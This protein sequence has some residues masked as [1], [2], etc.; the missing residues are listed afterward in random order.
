M[1][2]SGRKGN[3]GK[4]KLHS[5]NTHHRRKVGGRALPARTGFTLVELLVVIAIVAILASILMPVFGQAR[6]TAMRTR[7]ASNLRNIHNAVLMYAQDW[8]ECMPPEIKLEVATPSYGTH[9]ILMPYA[10]APDI[11]HCPA[12]TGDGRSGVP[13][14]QRFGMSYKA[15]G[16]CFSNPWDEKLQM[17]IIRRLSHLDMGIDTKKV[18]KG[19][20]DKEPQFL[21]QLQLMRDLFFPWEQGKE[22][23]KEGLVVRAW[24]RAGANVVF[25][26]GHVAFV[27][28]KAEWDAI[29]GKSGEGD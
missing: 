9:T 1:P 29:R 7:C 22:M 25:L 17:P 3:L 2:L 24:H 20:T 28:S 11:F 5:I 27:K 26:D 10:K 6:Q 15:E 19:E 8:R 21:A 4:M 18:L 23:K 16:R 14:W 12:D 13:V